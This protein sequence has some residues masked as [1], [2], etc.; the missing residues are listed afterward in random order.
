MR[1][2]RR[3]MALFWSW[4]SASLD[5]VGDSAAGG[6]YT[7][8]LS[9]MPFSASELGKRKRFTLDIQGGEDAKTMTWPHFSESGMIFNPATGW[10]QQGQLCPSHPSILAPPLVPEEEEL[11]VMLASDTPAGLCVGKCPA[12][13][14][15]AGSQVCGPWALYC[16]ARPCPARRWQITWRLGGPPEP[17]HVWPPARCELSPGS[18]HPFCLH[19][20]HLSPF[21]VVLQDLA[22]VVANFTKCLSQQLL[23]LIHTRLGGSYYPH[24]T[25]EEPEALT[26]WI[27]RPSS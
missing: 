10:S 6:L 5:G 13:Q 19:L 26:W 2:H 4:G 17:A 21:V 3:E 27:T 16:P 24:F 9:S 14:G 11:W 23:S 22:W 1:T 8:F 25:E 7:F 20:R 12:L 15:L 18:P